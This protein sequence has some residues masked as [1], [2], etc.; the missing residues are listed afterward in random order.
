MSTLFGSVSHNGGP[1]GLA[2]SQRIN[3]PPPELGGIAQLSWRDPRRRSHYPRHR[4]TE[5]PS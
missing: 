1:Y 3:V 2:A 5:H 4:H